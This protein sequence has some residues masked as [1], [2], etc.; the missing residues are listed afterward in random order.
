VALSTADSNKWALL[1]GTHL[2]W[3]TPEDR[4]TSDYQLL[5]PIR[6]RQRRLTEAQTIEIAARYEAR[7]TVYEIAAEFGCNRTTVAAR[8]KKAGI[9]MR[10]QPPTSEAIDSMAR[11]YASV[12]V[13][14]LARGS[15]Q[16]TWVLREHGAELP[17]E[18]PT[19]G[20][21][22]AWARPLSAWGIGGCRRSKGSR[23]AES[24]RASALLALPHPSIHE[25]MRRSRQVARERI[26]GHPL[27]GSHW[28]ASGEVL[29]VNARASLF[30]L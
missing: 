22:Y 18:T 29:L 25:A 20:P 1:I 28:L 27:R 5:G 15:R 8:L 7:A 17:A 11:L 30:T 2:E 19:P 26:P 21:R 9:A 14:T 3:Q 12:R 13:W 16:A 23:S 24:L 6:Q 10:G 4:T